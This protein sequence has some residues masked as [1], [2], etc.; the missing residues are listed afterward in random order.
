MDEELAKK[1]E[2]G[3][4]GP[5]DDVKI[6]ART[7]ADEYGWDVTD[8]RKI[9]CFVRDFHWESDGLAFARLTQVSTI[10]SRRHWRQLLGRHHQGCAVPQRNQGLLRCRFPM[11]YQGRSYGRGEHA[12]HQIQQC[13]LPTCLCTVK[14][15]YDLL[16]LN[17]AQSSMSPSTLM[18]STVVVV[19]SSRAFLTATISTPLLCSP[20]LCSQQ[21]NSPCHLRRC[22]LGQP[23]SARA[24]L[25]GRDPVPRDCLGRYLLDIEQKAWYGLLRGAA[26]RH[27][28]VHC[29]GLLARLRVLR[30]Q[31]RVA[32]S[33]RWSGLPSTGLRSL[34]V[35]FELANV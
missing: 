17:L 33:H 3:K 13:V 11:G 2:T 28:Y 30:F 22:S 21:N 12:F 29:Q 18:P 25:H 23:W 14:R 8:A 1:V 31:R 34:Y 19:K 27:P 15:A 9:W 16:F 20:Q 10:G 32:T 5:R 35:F 24:R 26:T 6:R 4:I 7:L